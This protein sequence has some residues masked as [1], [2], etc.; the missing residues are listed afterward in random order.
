MRAFENSTECVSK[1]L[2]GEHDG[3][4][5]SIETANNEL[6]VEGL[7]VEYLSNPLGIDVARPR[8]SWRL[9]SSLR[10]KRQTAYQILAASSPKALEKN[11]PDLW[12]SGKVQSDASVGVL[13]QGMEAKSG[14]RCYWKVRVWDEK[15]KPTPY[16]NVA[17]WE[18]GL[19]HPSDWKGQ[20][21]G[22]GKWKPGWAPL[23][24]KGF[25]V[26]KKVA[27][28]RAYICG[29]GYYELYIN[30]EKVGDHVLD[31]G[32][33]DYEARALYVTYDVVEFLK[34]GKNAIG[35]ILG[36][37]WYN[38]N[39]VWGGNLCYGQPRMIM[40][41]NIEYSDGS[42]S[43]IATDGTWKTSDSP[44]VLNNI[45]A[46][47]TYD[48]RL[49]QSGWN[50]PDFDDSGWLDAK[51][52]EGPGGALAPQM[53]PPIRKRTTIK[54]VKLTQ[55][56]FGIYVY[57]M[58]Q[59]FAGWARLRVQG[60]PGTEIVLRFAEEIDED[61]MINPE[62][63]GTQHTYV[64]QTDRYICKGEGIEV[65]EPRFTYHGFRYVEMTGFPGEP[66]VDNLEGVVVN[67][68]VDE[69]GRF[70]CSDPMIN[71]IHDTVKWTQLSNMHS[72]PEDCPARE[73]CGW[74][75]DAQIAAETTI[76]NWDVQAFWRKY[77]GDIKTTRELRGL[78]AMIAPGKRL[79][80]EATPAWGTAQVQL[81]WYLY[82]YYG[83]KEILREHYGLM[84]GW[85]EHL[86]GKSEGYIV[87][88][89]LGDWCPPGGNENM[90]APVPLT[91]TGYLYYDACIMAK[92]AGI[93]GYESD[94]EK[95]KD[96]AAKIKNAFN[97]R[98]FDEE[99]GTYGS[100][101]GDAF[102]LYLGLV[103]EGK[104]QAVADSIARDVMEVHDGHFTT[105]II[106]VKYIY[107]ALT[108]YGH[109]DVAQLLLNQ[110]T[111]PSYGH[112]FSMGAT[113]L[114]ESWEF[115]PPPGVSRRSRNHPMQGG[116]DAW[117]YTHLGGIMPDENEPG[118]KKI[119]I[120]PNIIGTL[121]W[122]NASYD[123]VYGRIMSNWKVEG[124][125]LQLN[126][127]IPPNT[128]A[129]VYVP[130]AGDGK[131]LEGDRPL[132]EA[133]GVKVL[134]EEGSRVV[135][136]VEPGIYRFCATYERHS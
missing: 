121:T 14:M 89:G 113:T 55:P 32:Q 87:S 3:G 16:S 114:W 98:F 107:G 41:L 103:P 117:F 88:Y 102:S 13:Y 115:E 79:C 7:R 48:A 17:W 66:T 34:D 80:A 122:V 94:A 109:G 76:Y 26:S 2:I 29:L 126:V 100:Q 67:T 33:T 1:A 40:Q 37:G 74:L 136:L 57:D 118:F 39:R 12:D 18:M 110:T 73:R 83:D 128:S 53:M 106:G 77:I 133:K 111:Y 99:R 38:Q 28:A 31:P 63:T 132:K 58:G 64:V 65:W 125:K 61:G 91:S 108:D 8:L 84:K 49:E 35:V 85:V 116:F 90:K 36:D 81:P 60:M 56:Q 9:V 97:E 24:R 70:E 25:Q 46:G 47:E 10:G 68:D 11:K 101:T 23:F 45:Y 92:V 123:S 19:L 62:S 21:I 134:G 124:N 15:D 27:K 6:M 119:I 82:V 127:V 20:W 5:A 104:E 42:V 30:G 4:C 93:L 105:G 71:R 51:V 96:L 95:Y 131:V 72:I 44:I 75:G 135:C 112:L 59:N 69:V 54:P 50:M 78:W 52:M 120:R 22:V 130:V 129:I 43:R 86:V